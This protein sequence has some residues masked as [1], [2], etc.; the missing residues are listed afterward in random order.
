MEITSHKLEK[1]NPYYQFDKKKWIVQLF[2]Q[3]Q[4]WHS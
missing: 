4:I 2:Q 3:N 1:I